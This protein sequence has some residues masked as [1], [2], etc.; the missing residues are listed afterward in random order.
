MQMLAAKELGH[1]VKWTS[2]RSEA[3]ASDSHGRANVIDAELALDSA[4]KFLGLC[5][6]WVADMGAYLTATGSASHTRNPSICMTGVYRIPALYGRFR[7]AS[8]HGAG[9]RLPRRGRPDIAYVI[10]RLLQPGRGGTQDRSGGT[11]PAQL[12]SARSLPL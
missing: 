8:P 2:T 4:G 11:A 9:G 12:D 3:M 1:A 6:N 7:L 10:E 5:L